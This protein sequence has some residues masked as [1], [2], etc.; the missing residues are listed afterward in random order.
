M[1]D[2]SHVDWHNFRYL[3]CDGRNRLD[4]VEELH[5]LVVITDVLLNQKAVRLRVDVLHR[6]LEPVESA[7]LGHL[8]YESQLRLGTPQ[9][10]YS[11]SSQLQKV[12]CEPRQSRKDN[13]CK[14]EQTWISS[15]KFVDKFSFTIPS[16]AAKK[17][18]TCLMKCCSSLFKP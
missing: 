16:D 6:H 8:I 18:K 7:S 11:G 3:R 1:K 10:V 4:S 17:A 5:L 9:A 12:I 13:S 2:R 14:P 15:E